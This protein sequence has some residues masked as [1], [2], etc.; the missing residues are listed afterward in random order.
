MNGHER[1]FVVTV[2]EPEGAYPYGP[3]GH[4]LQTAICHRLG[5]GGIPANGV[6]VEPY[7]VHQ[8]VSG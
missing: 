6:T 7:A 4:D 5:N 1:K 3:H 2:W 8:E